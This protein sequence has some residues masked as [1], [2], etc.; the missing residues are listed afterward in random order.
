MKRVLFLL[1][2]GFVLFGACSDQSANE[3]DAKDQDTNIAEQII[4]TWVE[5][6]RDVGTTWVFKTNG[7]LTRSNDDHDLNFCVNDKLLI[8]FDDDNNHYEMGLYH[9]SIS[10]NGKSL[11]LFRAYRESPDEW[12]GLSYSLTKN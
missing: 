2:A 11:F 1:I 12:V 6:Y 7:D 8:V 3:Q 5:Q 9:I 4:G 10:L